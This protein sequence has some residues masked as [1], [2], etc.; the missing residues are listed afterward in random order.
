MRS[1]GKAPDTPRPGVPDVR[2]H[3]RQPL[4]SLVG[5]SLLACVS[6][7]EPLAIDS[8]Q[9]QIRTPGL[10]CRSYGSHPSS[11]QRAWTDRLQP[12]SFPADTAPYRSKAS[13]VQSTAWTAAR[14]RVDFSRRQ[15]PRQAWRN[16]SS[17]RP[18][19]GILP[20]RTKNRI[21]EV[22]CSLGGDVLVY[23]RKEAF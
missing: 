1:S 20:S 11:S 23:P 22:H 12:D 5:C 19:L 17:F 21:G 7:N 18:R 15:S 8:G 16:Y 6:S 2:N 3:A 10:R 9:C 13:A 14:W 4:N